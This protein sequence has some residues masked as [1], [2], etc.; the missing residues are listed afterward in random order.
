MARF[1]IEK[2]KEVFCAASILAAIACRSRWRHCTW[3][4]L[5]SDYS[6]LY[7]MLVDIKTAVVAEMEQSLALNLLQK[8]WVAA[9]CIVA[10]SFLA[11]SGGVSK[12]LAVHSMFERLPTR[13]KLLTVIN[14]TI[15]LMNSLVA[16]PFTF[17][18]FDVTFSENPLDAVIGSRNRIVYGLNVLSVSFLVEAFLLGTC[19]KMNLSLYVHHIVFFIFIVSFSVTEDIAVL[20]S[21]LVLASLA[22]WQVFPRLTSFMRMIGVRRRDQ[23]K[24]AMLALLIG[25]V[26][27][28]VIGPFCL[29]KCLKDGVGRIDGTSHSMATYAGLVLMLVF[30]VSVEIYG[31]TRHQRLYVKLRAL[32]RESILA[33][34]HKDGKRCIKTR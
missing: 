5:Y 9:N 17:A 11:V 18:V 1:T 4:D 16:I 7:L 30:F 33:W 29:F 22:C 2:A 32:A 19:F 15:F 25:A 12:V 24:S 28:F 27:R 23:K 21:G 31:V 13:D 20:K 6:Y 14:L 34:R 10:L 3:M 8:E 26:T